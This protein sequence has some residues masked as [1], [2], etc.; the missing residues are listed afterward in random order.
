MSMKMELERLAETR[1]FDRASPLPIGDGELC[2]RYERLYTGAVNDVLR[3]FTLMH[4]TLP[5]DIVPLRDG[6]KA[7]GIAFTIRSAKDPSINLDGEMA[8]RAGM[9]SAIPKDAMCL[10]DT[11]R[12]DLAAHWGG[13]MTAATKRRGARGA[14]VDGGIRDTHQILEED[15][16]VFY[17]YRTS[18][19]ALGRVK[20]VAYEVPIT[21]GEVIVYPGDL[22]LADLDGALVVPRRVACEVLER[23]EAIV[24]HEDDIKNWIEDGATATAIVDRG[25]YF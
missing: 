13:M 23:A 20:I 22:V 5:H 1:R 11:N 8:F 25:G 16:P 24:R 6:M 18:N 2:D 7:A 15:F 3:E 12:D 10:W 9:L 4:Q 14:I 19:G 21:I 17:R